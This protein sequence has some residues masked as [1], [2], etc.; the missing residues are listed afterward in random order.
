MEKNDVFVKHIEQHLDEIFKKEGKVLAVC[1]KICG[2]T[3]DEI[4]EENLSKG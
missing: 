2:K 4:Y 3:I 1:C